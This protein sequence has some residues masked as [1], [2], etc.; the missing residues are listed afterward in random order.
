MLLCLV[1]IGARRS[2]HGRRQVF[3]IFT[4]FFNLSTLK[5]VWCSTDQVQVWSLGQQLDVGAAAVDA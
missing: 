2:Q 5:F 1:S 4:L 3:S